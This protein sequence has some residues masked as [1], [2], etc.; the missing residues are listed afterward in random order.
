MAL[1]ASFFGGK[2]NIPQFIP[3]NAQAIQQ[4]TLTGNSAAL[5]QTIEQTAA[6][7][8]AQFSN[9][10][11][12]LAQATGGYYDRIRNSIGKNTADL[13][14]GVIP[15]DVATAVK[16]NAAQRALYGGFA[17]S[18]AA[19][20]LTARDLGLTSLDLMS[21]GLDSATKWMNAISSTYQPVSVA[22]MF[23]RNTYDLPTALSH[24]VNERNAQFQREYVEKQWSWFNSFGQQ[25]TRFEDSLIQLVGD[26]AGAA[27]G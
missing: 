22:S 17:G 13:V 18:G 8:A 16:T 21:K 9:I 6:I 4:Q 15:G 2:P 3:V 5:P 26:V 20:N 7:N 1:L 11:K 23:A 12:L 14:A 19:S 27:M 24:A 10:D 25:A